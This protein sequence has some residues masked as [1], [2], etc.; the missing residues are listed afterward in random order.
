MDQHIS[1]PEWAL[2]YVKSTVCNNDSVFDGLLRGVLTIVCAIL[3]ILDFNVDW[4]SIDIF[5]IDLERSGTSFFSVDSK[6]GGFPL[7]D[8]ILL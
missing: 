3:V 8:A 6:L 5:T 4:L 7:D 2:W 1:Y